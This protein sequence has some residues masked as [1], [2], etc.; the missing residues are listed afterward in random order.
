[1]PHPAHMFTEPQAQAFNREV[2]KQLDERRA[3][4]KARETQPQKPL[5]LIVFA[6]A[7][8]ARAARLV[9]DA[10]PD[11]EKILASVYEEQN[12][13]FTLETELLAILEHGVRKMSKSDADHARRKILG[14][15]TKE[16]S[17]PG[18]LDTKVHVPGSLEKVR[19]K[20]TDIER[21]LPRLQ[22]EAAVYANTK[23]SLAPWPWSKINRLRNDE[24]DQE[25]IMNGKLPHP[26]GGR[27]MAGY[28]IQP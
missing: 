4:A 27:S 23:K 26:R 6:D 19:E 15:E 5:E 21:R 14:Y 8:E 10:Q 9:F 17:L 20:L 11:A 25:Q 18:V 3:R 2:T 12:E 1:M 13:L 7:D 24:L 28:T 16:P 22:H